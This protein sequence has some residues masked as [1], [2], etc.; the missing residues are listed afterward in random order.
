MDRLGI[1]ILDERIML[2][3]QGRVIDSKRRSL[4]V[5]PREMKPLPSA[6]PEDTLTE[7]PGEA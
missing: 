5:P 1:A 2:D 3:S 7:R 4:N 6:P